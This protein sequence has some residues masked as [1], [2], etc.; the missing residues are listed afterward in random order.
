LAPYVTHLRLSSVLV[1]SVRSTSSGAPADT[2][3][4]SS[5]APD[6][7][8]AASVAGADAAPPAS[9]GVDLY[10]TFATDAADAEVVIFAAEFGTIWLSNEPVGSDETG[11]R[12]VTPPDVYGTTTSGGTS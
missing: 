5:P 10:V 9:A 3:A 11:T 6:A 7:A 2:T 8:S 1:T 4:T 12:I